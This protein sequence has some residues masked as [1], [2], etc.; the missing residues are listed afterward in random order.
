[1]RFLRSAKWLLSVSLL[2]MV[3]CE[4]AE[5]TITKRVSYADL[6]VTYNAEVQTLD[7]LEGKRKS[8]LAEYANQAQEDALKSALNSLG[9]AGAPSIS[10]NPNDALQQA[11]AAAESQAKMLN[12]LGQ[13]TSGSNASLANLELPEEAK[14]KLVALDKEITKQKERVDRARVARDEAESK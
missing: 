7:N 5:I 11:V 3:G 4:P 12:Q 14:A 9:S 8:L 10:S 6:V 1:M 13:S 2:C